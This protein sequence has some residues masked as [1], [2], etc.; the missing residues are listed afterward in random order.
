MAYSVCLYAVTMV[1]ICFT[2][3]ELSPPLLSREK[4]ILTTIYYSMLMLTMFVAMC[5][6]I[7]LWLDASN[8]VHYI[9]K[10]TEFQV[11]K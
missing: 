1:I 4:D 6:P 3:G 10:W 9:N 7:L 11:R 2:V 8:F 5:T